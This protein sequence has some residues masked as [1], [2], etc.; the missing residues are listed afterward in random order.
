MS[1][2]CPLQPISSSPVRARPS[3]RAGQA[4]RARLPRL[5]RAAA[6]PRGRPGPSSRA[7]GGRGQG[8]DGGVRA[9]SRVSQRARQVTGVTGRERN[10]HG[11]ASKWMVQAWLYRGVKTSL[12]VVVAIF[13]GTPPLLP[14]SRTHT[15]TPRLELLPVSTAEADWP[16]PP[17]P[18]SPNT[19]LASAHDLPLRTQIIPASP[20]LPYRNA[21]P[22][23]AAPT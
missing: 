17:S 14:L 21:W 4:G 18:H 11:F 10:G 20:S 1:A 13:W 3:V 12:S 2:V 23:H 9:R 8:G 19:L 15:C 16:L 7:G 22:Y 5:A 6:A